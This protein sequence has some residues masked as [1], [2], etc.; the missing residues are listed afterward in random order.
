M[1]KNND[2]YQTISISTRINKFSLLS[3]SLIS[4]FFFDSYSPAPIHIFSSLTNPIEFHEVSVGCNR[5]LSL[6]NSSLLLW[7]LASFPLG[8][9]R[10][11]N[12]KDVKN[13]LWSF[14]ASL[15]TNWQ[16]HMESLTSRGKY[17]NKGLTQW[18]YFSLFLLWRL[19]CYNRIIPQ[20]L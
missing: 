14:L 20:A 18:D 9:T 12:M 7:C 19:F 15:T 16:K 17:N 5:L 2:K 4:V 3:F 1:R 6:D 10:H 8:I 11:E 13:P